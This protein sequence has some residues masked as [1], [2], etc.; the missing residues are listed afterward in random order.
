MTTADPIYP[1][2]YAR[3]DIFLYVSN[4]TEYHKRRGACKKEPETIKWI[5]SLPKG[6]VLFDIGANVG[7]YSLL[8]A[9][10]GLKVVAFEAS[11]PNFQRLVQNFELN[12]LEGQF[13]EHPLWKCQETIEFCY[14]SREVGAALHSVNGMTPDREM[15]PAF[16]LDWWVFEAQ[17]SLRLPQPDHLKIDV[18]GCELE[19]L[20]GASRTLRKVRSLLVESDQGQPSHRVIRPLLEDGGF[21]VESSHPH[22]SSPVS[23]VIYSKA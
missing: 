12:D 17:D 9:K 16:P 7:S 6:S 23:N 1:M 15:K 2:D 21:R 18:D 5:E 19:V 3:A 22:G 4:H 20:E 8:A 10:L 13:I 14:S 11:T